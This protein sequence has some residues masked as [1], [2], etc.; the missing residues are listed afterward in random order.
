MKS[1]LVAFNDSVSSR[2]AVDYLAGLL[3]SGEEYQITLIHIFRSPTASE[4][5]MGKKFTQEQ[6]IRIKKALERAQAALKSGNL[7]DLA[8][9]S[10]KENATLQSL[11]EMAQHPAMQK[12]LLD[13]PVGSLTPALWTPEGQVWIARIKARTPAEPLTFEKRQTLVQ[14]IQSAVSMKLL[15]AELEDLDTKGR[16]RPGFSSLW[17]RLSGIY[18]NTDVSQKT[19]AEIPE[20]DQD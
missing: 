3:H 1:I 7:A 10:T 18:V 16:L 8:V 4:E 14:G 11:V 20:S 9:P 6:P 13:T 5:L 19:M 15:S 17:G 2:A 12:A